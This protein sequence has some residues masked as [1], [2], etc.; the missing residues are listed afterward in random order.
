MFANHEVR[1]MN[2]SLPSRHD[3]AVAIERAVDAIRQFTTKKPTHAVILGSGLGGIAEKIQD[4]VRIDFADIPGFATSTAAG[5]QGQLILGQLQGKTLVTMAGR[6][7]RYEGHPRAAV[8]FP[9][10]VMNAM[11]ATNLIVSNA[12]GGLNPDFRV[13]DLVVIRDHLDWLSGGPMA[14]QTSLSTEI[15]NREIPNRGRPIYDEQLGDLA[16][17]AGLRDNFVVHRGTYL[18]TLG[19]NYETRAEYRMMRRLGADL[20]GMSTVPEA[21][22]ASE[23]RMRVLALSMVSNVANPDAPEI[24]NHEEVLQAGVAA[25]A[26]ME[27]IVRQV[28]AQT[29]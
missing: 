22:Q 16:I 18:A 24:A 13:G 4:A 5:H 1:K 17:D 21:I 10:C 8:T 15:P 19:P 14:I 28:V 3:T 12:A 26:K 6:L 20:A 29:N 23:L 7:H 25:A 11:G 2:S 9:V 27:A